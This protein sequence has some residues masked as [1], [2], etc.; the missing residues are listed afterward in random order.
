MGFAVKQ[1]DFASDLFEPGSP[2]A[3]VAWHTVE[4]VPDPVAFIRAAYAAL[5]PGGRLMPSTPNGTSYG[6]IHM[7]QH[8]RGLEVLRHLSLHN[9]ASLRA[10]AQVARFADIGVLGTPHGGFIWQQSHQLRKGSLVST[11]QSLRTLP[12]NVL[13][14]AINVIAPSK[15]NEIILRCVK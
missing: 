9:P 14:A 15:S 7:R 2:D 1:G 3:V 10:M 12:Y 4:H 6:A 5:K 13:A 8:W 11:R